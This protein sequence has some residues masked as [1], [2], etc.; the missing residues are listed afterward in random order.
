MKCIFSKE[1]CLFLFFFF[2]SASP[3]L[4]TEC[5][6]QLVQTKEKNLSL[7]DAIYSLWW[8]ASRAQVYKIPV[9]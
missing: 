6:Q 7:P 2:F 5:T 3:S 8:D 9:T 4:L 1:G